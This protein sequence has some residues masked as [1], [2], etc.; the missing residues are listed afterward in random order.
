MTVEKKLVA[1]KRRARAKLH[2]LVAE[3][4]SSGVR[5]SEFCLSR[6]V[7]FDAES[8]SEEARVEEKE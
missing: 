4:R 1:P 8:S 3:F 2:R 7:S 5:R 6:G